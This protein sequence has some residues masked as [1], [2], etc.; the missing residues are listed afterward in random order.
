MILYLEPNQIIDEEII[1]MEG[2]D[3]RGQEEFFHDRLG[4]WR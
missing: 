1:L 2:D 3:E 4:N